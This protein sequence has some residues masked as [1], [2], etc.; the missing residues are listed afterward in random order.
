MW[1]MNIITFYAISKITVDP[2]VY[3]GIIL[4]DTIC[5]NMNNYLT[6]QNECFD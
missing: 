5:Y 2:N 3:Q 4:P 6:S 1:E